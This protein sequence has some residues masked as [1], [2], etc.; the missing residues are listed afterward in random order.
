MKIYEI[1][2]DQYRKKAGYIEAIHKWGLPGVICPVCKSTWSTIGLEYPT[3]D[4]NGFADETL[5]RKARTEPLD[6]F[7]KLR[8]KI[9]NAFPKLTVL[10]PGTE[11][12][13]LKGKAIGLMDGFVWRSWWTISLARTALEQLK[14]SS[15][16][17]PDSAKAELEFKREESEIYELDLPLQGR[18]VN[19][20]YDSSQLNYCVA[21]GRDSISKPEK[22]LIDNASIPNN[23]DIFRVSNFTTIILVTERFVETVNSLNIKGAV[24]EEVETK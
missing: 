22:I 2:E 8:Q 13:A 24:F 4:L 16:L 5:Y 11:F 21:C 10:N 19:G 6:E 12:G 20:I 1:R 3:V 14:G 17:L 9:K 7:L 23:I 15:L 18:L